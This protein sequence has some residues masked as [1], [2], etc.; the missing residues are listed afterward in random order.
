[1]TPEVKQRI[2][3]IRH[4]IV[5][6]GYKKTKVVIIPLEW[7][8]TRFKKKFS[9]VNRRNSEGNTNVLTISAQHGL[10]NQEEF[11]NKSVAS[12]DKSTYFLV[13]KGEYAY[14]K[15]YSAGYPF[16]AL[17]RLERYDSGVVSPLY[18]CFAPTSDNECPE[19][20]TQYFEAGKMNP[21]IQAFAQEGARNHG[22]LNISVDDFFNS[23]IIAPPLEEQKKIVEVLAKQDRIIELQQQKIDE[24][25]KM[26]KAYLSKIFPHNGKKVP[27]LRFKGFTGDWE[28]RKCGDMF[29]IVRRKNRDGRNTNVITNSAEY[30]LIPQRDFFDKD[31]AVEGKTDNYTVIGKGDFVYNPRKSITAPFGPFNCYT[32]DDEGIVSPLYT[33][34]TPQNPAN[35]D[36]L[37]WYFKTDRWHSFIRLNGAQG[38]ARHDRVGMTNELMA[39]IPISI[40]AS[41]EEQNKIAAFFDGLDNTIAL[42]QRKLELEKHKKKTLMQLLLTGIVRVKI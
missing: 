31:I 42:H 25:K 19:F 22:L 12:E 23:I 34:L 27:E 9:R 21:E 2:E 8:E 29:T 13:K 6:E 10:I 15:S 16:G 17:K 28:Q 40:P 36:Y 39:E 3:Q 38:G 5:P 41:I 30:G 37:L 26:K 24:L 14:N 4:G 20:Y 7:E 18:I 1:M 11:F 33:C 35:T 32:H